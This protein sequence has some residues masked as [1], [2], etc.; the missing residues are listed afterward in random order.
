MYRQ[1][2][3]FWSRTILSHLWENSYKQR[4]TPTVF[5][6]YFRKYLKETMKFISDNSH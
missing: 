6:F 1:V 2:L 3:S 4:K 5:L